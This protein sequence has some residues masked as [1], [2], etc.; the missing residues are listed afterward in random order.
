[1]AK[2]DIKTVRAQRRKARVRGKITGM[3]ERPRLTISKSLRNITA[4]IVDDEKMITLTAVSTLSKG[5]GDKI[6]GK[7]KTDAAAVIGEELAKRA[8]EKG[9]KKIAF[10]RNRNIFHGRIKAL[11]DAA[12]KSGLEF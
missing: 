7:T 3:A 5:I 12:R 4:Q 10:D 8:L 9:I 1:M 6:K 2:K 11:A